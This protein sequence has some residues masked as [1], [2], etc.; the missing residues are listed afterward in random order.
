MTFFKSQMNFPS[1]AEES[2]HYRKSIDKVFHVCVME[3]NFVL[4]CT[5]TDILFISLYNSIFRRL[6]NFQCIVLWGIPSSNSN[7]TNW[8]SHRLCTFLVKKCLEQ[9]QNRQKMFFCLHNAITFCF[10]MFCSDISY[11]RMG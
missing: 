11:L 2:F 7:N 6:T 10:N 9:F 5:I 4:V 1:F 3:V 8:N